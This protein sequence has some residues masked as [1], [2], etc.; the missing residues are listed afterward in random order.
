MALR[1]QIHILSLHKF[2]RNP[3]QLFMKKI[4]FALL[5]VSTAAFS[6]ET[7]TETPPFKKSFVAKWNPASLAFGKLSLGTEFN[8]KHKKSVTLNIGIPMERKYTFELDNADREINLKTTSIMGGYRMYMG[9]R[10]M[11][12]FY[13]E[14]YLKYVSNKAE[15]PKYST[16]INGRNADFRMTSEYSGV[17]VGAQL[18]V[19]FMIAKVI[20]FDLFILG[21]EANSA[22]ETMSFKEEGNNIPW[23]MIDANDAKRELQE[24]VEDIP[25]IGKKIE[26]TIDQANK[27]VRG[28]YKG[29]LPGF[30]AGLSLGIRF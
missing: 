21:P 15:I 1:L 14:P 22:K 17:G 16:T 25:I 13:F 26:I 4:L 7:K 6:Q 9:K 27:T 11:T 20:A 8:F 5:L 3:N 30:R 2:I 28:E 19:Q 10:D 23:S 12:G 29:F 18:G 24:A